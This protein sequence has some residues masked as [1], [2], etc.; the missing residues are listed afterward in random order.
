MRLTML[1]SRIAS[2][3]AP[4]AAALLLGTGILTAAASAQVDRANVMKLLNRSDVADQL[5]LMGVD[6][7]DTRARVAAMSDQEIQTLAGKLHALPAGA[8]GS[9]ILI[10]LIVLGLIYWFV[11][12]K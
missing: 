7:Q 11:W 1:W 8:D 12:K 5:T 2:R 6:P 3:L 4:G 9:S 10:L